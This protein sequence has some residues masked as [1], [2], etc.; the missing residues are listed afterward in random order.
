MRNIVLSEPYVAK[1]QKEFVLDCIERNWLGSGGNFSNKLEE[2]FSQ[3]CG[4]QYAETCSNGTTALHLALL[5]IGVN[6]GDEIILPALNSQYALFAVYHARANPVIIDVCEDWS[7]DLEQLVKAITPRTRGIIISHLFGRPIDLSPIIE[8][9][10][11]YGIKIIEDCAEAHGAEVKGKKVG[12][13]G[14]VGT[15]SFYSNK[16][17]GAGEGGICVTNN[18]EIA[19]K[20]AYFKNQTFNKGLIKTLFHEDIGYNYRLGEIAAAIAYSQFLEIDEILYKRDIISSEYIIHLSKYFKFDSPLDETRSV[21]WMFL[22]DVSN[23]VINVDEAIKKLSDVGVPSRKFFP[24][25]D[26]QP[27]LNKFDKVKIFPIKYSK[28]IADSKIYLPTYTVMTND[29]IEL[30]SNLVIKSL[31]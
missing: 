1:K 31:I 4:C 17:I 19:E 14:D 23:Y 28:K 18:K 3:F 27:C 29:E 12:G 5:G 6:P 30:V 21:N 8:I 26:E 20:I 11:K 25:L 13:L 22:L 24:S 2:E 9:A 7:P 16:I 15:F 10:S